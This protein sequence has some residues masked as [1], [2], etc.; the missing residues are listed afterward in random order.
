MTLTV[1]SNLANAKLRAPASWCDLAFLCDEN[2]KS[3]AENDDSCSGLSAPSPLPSVIT[4]VAVVGSDPYLREGS[5]LTFIF[6]VKAKPGFD[7]ALA[8]ALSGHG[9]RHGGLQSSRLEQDGVAITVSRSP[10]GAVRQHRAS[11]D[12]FELVSNSPSA[13][14]RVIGTLRGHQRPLFWTRGRHRSP[15]WVGA[16]ATLA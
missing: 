5:D 7:M 8:S 3:S 10:D 2:E 14:R 16:C 4:D 12:G 1:E 9:A 6:R 13:I 15:A 11:V